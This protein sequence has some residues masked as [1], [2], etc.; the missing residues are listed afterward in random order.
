MTNPYAFI[1]IKPTVTIDKARKIL[2]NKSNQLNDK[3]IEIIVASLY[4]LAN[5]IIQN[6]TNQ[7]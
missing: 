5:R 2:G 3:Q 7:L 1:A 6:Q 4:R